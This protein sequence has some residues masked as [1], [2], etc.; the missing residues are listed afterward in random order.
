MPYSTHHT[1]VSGVW[2]KTAKAY[3]RVSGVWKVITSGWQKL[4]GTWTRIASYQ[5]LVPAG[6]IVLFVGT[7]VPTGWTRVSAA[8]GRMIIG[9]GSSFSALDTGGST[10][11]TFSG[12]T[13]TTGNHNGG[14]GSGVGSPSGSGD[15]GDGNVSRG[16]HS[17][18]YNT[19]AINT[20]DAYKDFI[21]IKADA[22][23]YLPVDAVVLSASLL[24]DLSNTEVGTNRFFR[25]AATYGGTGGS[26]AS[27]SDVGSSSAG[28]HRHGQRTPNTGGGFLQNPTRGSHSH[29]VTVSWNLSTYFMGSLLKY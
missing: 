15:D 23:A 5:Q 20:E 18:T 3:V 4:V 19:G 9:A 2:K 12:S 14:S 28:S 7:V 16:S 29:T 25:G 27:N 26:D 21:L 17:H 6:G 10:T 1:R 8:D 24:A 11:T 13:N 22:D